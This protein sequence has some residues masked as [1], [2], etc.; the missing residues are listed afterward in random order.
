MK[1]TF[2]PQWVWVAGQQITS[3]VEVL[4]TKVDGLKENVEKLATAQSITTDRV[5]AL[6]MR[7]KPNG[8]RRQ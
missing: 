8:T 6:M 7:K 2:I 1:Q 3:K 5:T 4:G